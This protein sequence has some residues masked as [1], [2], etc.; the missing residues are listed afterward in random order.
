MVSRLRFIPRIM[1]RPHGTDDLRATFG[2]GT[3][4]AFYRRLLWIHRDDSLLRYWGKFPAQFSAYDT[5]HV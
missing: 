2:L 3:S 5:Y 4:T 1:G